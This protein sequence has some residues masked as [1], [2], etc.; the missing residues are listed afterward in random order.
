MIIDKIDKLRQPVREMSSEN[1]VKVLKYLQNLKKL[2]ILY[3]Q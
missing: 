1:Q 2:C 3:N